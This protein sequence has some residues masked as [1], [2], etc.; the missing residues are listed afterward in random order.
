MI[1]SGRRRHARRRGPILTRR[2]WCAHPMIGGGGRDS[3][4]PHRARWYRG[5]VRWLVAAA[6][7]GVGIAATPADARERA[8]RRFDSISHGIEWAILAED[9]GH[10][11]WA[12]DALGLLRFDGAR[13][14]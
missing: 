5:T 12:G 10:E 1:P 3:L 13:F 11:L 4:E 14:H 7:L 6:L 2:G 8:V 9:A